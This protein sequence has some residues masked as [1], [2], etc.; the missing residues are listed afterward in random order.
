MKIP[1]YYPPANT[2]I[3]GRD[4]QSVDDMSRA[5]VW[6]TRPEPTQQE[7]PSTMVPE[8][9]TPWEAVP[10]QNNNPEELYLLIPSVP[11]E[12]EGTSPDDLT[13]DE[14]DEDD[15]NDSEHMPEGTDSD[16]WDDEEEYYSSDDY[17]FDYNSVDGFSLEG[18]CPHPGTLRG[19]VDGVVCEFTPG[20]GFLNTNDP[21]FPYM[22]YPLRFRWTCC[23]D[24]FGCH[25]CYNNP[26]FPPT[27]TSQNN[28]TV[29]DSW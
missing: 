24:E 14:S 27:V 18:F 25:F 15:G 6:R 10:Q 16:H 9:H 21:W 26:P 28:P 1:C 3:G 17:L 23:G 29:T 4:F 13:S 7:H 20:D 2:T 11:S 19:V 8:E 22:Q 12:S 5:P